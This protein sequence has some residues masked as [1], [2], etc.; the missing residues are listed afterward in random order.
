MTCFPPCLLSFLSHHNHHHYILK[1]TKKAAPFFEKKRKLERKRKQKKRKNAK[2]QFW[3]RI[4]R[5]VNATGPDFGCK[6]RL[7]RSPGAS[8]SVLGPVTAPFLAIFHLFFFFGVAYLWRSF[9]T[10]HFSDN[11]RF[12]RLAY[13]WA[14]FTKSLFPLF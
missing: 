6:F 14:Y 12:V 2:S 5:K 4:T 3:L 11:S 10:A 1:N 8:K 13:L 9:N 7:R